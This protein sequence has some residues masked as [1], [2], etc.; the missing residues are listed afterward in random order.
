MVERTSRRD[1]LGA[2]GAGAAIAVAGCIEGSSTLGFGGEETTH[3]FNPEEVEEI[4]DNGVVAFVYHDGPIEDYELALP[5]HEEFDVPATTC[6]VTNW[7]G[8]QDRLDEG[9]LQELADAGWEIGSH[10]TDHS[11]LGAFTLVED[12]EPGDTRVYAESH[13]HG[14]HAG[15]RVELTDGDTSATY[16]AA[17]YDDDSNGDRYVKLAEPIDTAFTAGE[18]VIRYPQQQ[19]ERALADS[20]AEL[21]DMGFSVETLL[22][23]YDDFD[24]Y[25]R[26]LVEEHYEFVANADQSRPRVN[27]PFDFDPYGLGHQYFLE[28]M[29]PSSVEYEL[30]DIAGSSGLGVFGTHTFEDGFSQEG[31][32]TT[33]EAIEERDIT[34][35]TLQEAGRRYL[36]HGDEA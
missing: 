14:I 4:P 18:S 2:V 16:T 31:L 15:Y 6:P 12:A 20:K 11:T 8:R 27:Y 9:H 32:R 26:P 25:A 28:F 5:V 3:E 7:I 35:L 19:V 13:R 24:A 17:D 23:P 30:D 34:V 33:L 22:A 21:E 10:T 36:V 1:V 29:T